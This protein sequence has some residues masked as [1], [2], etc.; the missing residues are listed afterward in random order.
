MKFPFRHSFR[1]LQRGPAFP[2]FLACL[3]IGLSTPAWAD[4]VKPIHFGPFFMNQITA[5]GGPMGYD[6]VLTNG[7][8]HFQVGWIEPM[9]QE[10]TGLFMGTYFESNGNVN[11]SPYTSDV[12]T[13][14]NLKPLRYLEMGLSYNRM[15]FH[16]SLVSFARPDG[17][18]VDKKLY[19]PDQL[20]LFAK[21][22][23]GADI[24]S[25]Q[26]N[27]TIDLGRAQF[28]Q[29]ASRSLWDVDAE[30]K[31]YFFEYGDGL[32][33]ATRDRV[34]Y[35]ITQLTF[36]LRQLSVFSQVSFVGLAVRNQYW[37]T[38]QTEIQ[39]NL[40]SAG[41]TGLRI[42]RNPRQHRRGLDFSIG[43][44]TLHDQLPDN[45]FAKSL[46]LIAD[47][48]WNIQVLKI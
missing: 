11:V 12:G 13:T 8:Y 47:W 6:Y 5:A 15:M 36:D 10:K 29:Y 9:S 19:R 16:N 42:G 32:L 3:G 20:T 34:N 26:A 45:D 24:F 30:G 35:F 23:G 28:Y 17:S 38:D 27:L 40:V 41:I 21:S 46:V 7:F 31:D 22:P 2:A 48:Q 39:K 44:F 1:G 14:F 33:M 18:K 43:Y 4:T 25:Y 37:I